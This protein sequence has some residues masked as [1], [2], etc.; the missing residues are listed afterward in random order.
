VLA[1]PP[2]ADTK[3]YVGETVTPTVPDDVKI[4]IADV[5]VREGSAWLVATS[6]TELGDGTAAG[7]R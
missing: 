2:E 1:E 5:P 4:V 7:A 6:E 3:A